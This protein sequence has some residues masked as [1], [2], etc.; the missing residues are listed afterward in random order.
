MA[1]IVLDPLKVRPLF[2]GITSPMIATVA[3]QIGR[4]VQV[5]DTLSGQVVQADASAVGTV[6]GHIGMV[7]GAG[8]K[9]TDGVIAAGETCDVLWFGRVAVDVTLDPLGNLYVSDTAGVIAD[10][11]GTS[12]RRIGKPETANVLFFNPEDVAWASA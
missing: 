1:D 11:A 7:V 12:S 3:T 9:G 6:S 4:I 5:H 10:A 2:G 8:N